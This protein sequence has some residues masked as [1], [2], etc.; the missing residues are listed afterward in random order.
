MGKFLAI[1]H[2]TFVQSLRQP[3][4]CIL[5]LV[6]C[7]AMPL[8]LAGT[9]WSM[10]ESGGDYHAT[11]QKQFQDFG[12]STLLSLGAMLAVFSASSAITREIEDQTAL[13]VVSKPVPRPVF[14]LG[15][16]AGVSAAV[17]L[18]YYLGAIAFLLALRHGVVTAASDPIDWPVIVIGCMALGLALA[19]AAGGNYFFSWP[20]TS[21]LIWSM[22]AC[23][24]LA[25]GITLFVGKGWTLVPPGYDEPPRTHNLIEVRLADQKFRAA[26]QDRATKQEFALV[27]WEYHQPVAYL[28][29]AA[30]LNAEESMA[31]L[32]RW[33]AEGVSEVGKQTDPPV[34]RQQL[35][36][37]MAL[38]YM[39][40]LALAAIAVTASTRLGLVFTLLVC[41]GVGVLGALA[42]YLAHSGHGNFSV[43]LL[44]WLL[45]NLAYF[46]SLDVLAR[47]FDTAIPINFVAMAALYC[48]LYV[49]GVLA[50]GIALFQRRQMA[51][52]SGGGSV[53]GAVNL[54]A[55][56]GRSAAIILG[57]GA[58]V[59]LAQPPMHNARGLAIVAALAAAG[60]GNWFL[61]GYFGH[62]AK[63]AWWLVM[64]LSGGILV[65]WALGAI[66]PQIGERLRAGA[67]GAAPAAL[68]G[69]LAATT[70]L[71]LLLPRTRRHFQSHSQKAA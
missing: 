14:L 7:I 3:I 24:T 49:G 58:L 42:P 59:L 21:A 5:V 39:S 64:L 34:I 30:G 37:G 40:L 27:R 55:G 18:A 61:W 71:I 41:L 50:V 33:R 36:A 1:A 66:A 47:P 29:P 8:L 4:A 44:V 51:A 17:T 16:F 32:R 70:M 52:E 13:T 35:L 23:L 56:L 22:T 69:A 15:K 25:L 54:L 38:N 48:L 46:Y 12:L 28:Q 6:A 20:F 65:R 67:E 10:G 62:G 68:L 2:N 26:F 57:L 53:P 19:I 60:V 11:D 63:W 45:P 31:E 9:G 43:R